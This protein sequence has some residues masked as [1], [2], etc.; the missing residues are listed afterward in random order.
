ME[1]DLIRN[2]KIE[3]INKDKSFFMIDEV[4]VEKDLNIHIKD[5]IIARLLISPKDIENLTIGYLYNLGYIS[6]IDDINCIRIEDKDSYVILN[7]QLS[8]EIVYNTKILRI[9]KNDLFKLSKIFQNKSEI[10]KRTGGAHSVGLIKD[11]KIVKFVEDVSRSNAV[12]KLIGHILK[13]KIDI[14]DKFIFTSCRVNEQIIEKIEKV[15]FSLIVSQSSPTSRA[16]E[17]A[18]SKDINLIGFARG[19]RFNIYNKNKNLIV[20]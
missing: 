20:E 17:I 3:K 9:K 16:V 13:E 15:G 4:I 8:K 2:F 12:D 19:E 6:S 1:K 5:E 7:T 18:R 14:S 11:C 10:F